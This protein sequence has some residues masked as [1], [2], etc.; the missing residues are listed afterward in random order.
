[1]KMLLCVAALLTLAAC[2]GDRGDTGMTGATGA[3]GEVVVVPA[4][5]P[6]PVDPIA[7]IIADEN[8][9]RLALGQTMLSAGLSC[10]L[11]SITGGDRI[12]SSIAGHN[13]LSGV[14]T[15]STY[16]YAGLF[17]QPDSPISEGM[18]VL[19]PAL[20]AIY[21]NMYLLRCTGQLV[22]LTSGHYGFELS[23]DDAS[24]LYIDGAK[25]IDNDNNHGTTLVTGQRY[26]RKGVHTIR[27]DYAQTGAGSQSLQLTSGGMSIDPSLYFH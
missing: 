14:S 25:V 2:A 27:L 20:R 1:M 12:Q 8:E 10:T 11:Y 26:L 17:N 5:A 6:T 15:V 13:T 24:L 3:P 4:P 23:S 18:N 16:L 22:V 21:K 9:Y 7:A 19:P